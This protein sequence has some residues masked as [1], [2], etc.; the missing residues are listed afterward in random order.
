MASEVSIRFDPADVARFRASM[1]K[2][3]RELKLSCADS[4]RVGAR[5]VSRS[6]AASTKVAKEYRKKER[7]IIE[8][9]G[10]SMPTK[11]GKVRPPRKIAVWGAYFDKRGGQWIPLGPTPK[12]SQNYPKTAAQ[13]KAHP[14]LR[15]Y[16]RGL[17]KASW[18]WSGRD[19]GERGV[20]PDGSRG[21][22]GT[23]RKFG[24]S[25]SHLNGL[26]PYVVMRSK[27]DYASRAFKEGKQAV[28]TAMARATRQMLHVISGRIKMRG[29][30]S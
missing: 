18:W 28:S 13:A 5:V 19:V 7:R 23:A 25:E 27:L 6:L 8:V 26:S 2:L 11:S 17:A 24:T 20:P 21:A 14:A 22:I 15:I 1:D 4:V 9:Q 10:P 30:N 3:Q 29:I 16:K 12:G